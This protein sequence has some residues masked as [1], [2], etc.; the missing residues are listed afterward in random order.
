MVVWILCQRH[1]L[2]FSMDLAMEAQA[3]VSLQ[4]MQCLN[5]CLTFQFMDIYQLI[6]RLYLI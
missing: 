1:R 6:T 2:L 5:Y 3:V 4:E